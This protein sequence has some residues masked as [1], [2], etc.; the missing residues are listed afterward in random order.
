M[1]DSGDLYDP[2]ISGGRV[3]VFQFGEFPVI[4]SYLQVFCLEHLN[5]GLYLDGVDDFV[6]LD[7]IPTLEMEE[8]YEQIFKAEKTDLNFT[9]FLKIILRACKSISR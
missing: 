4:W 8:R 5:Q 1:V 9:C 7:D 2:T 3:G 6:E